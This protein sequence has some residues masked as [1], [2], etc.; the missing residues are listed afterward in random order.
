[1]RILLGILIT[2]CCSQL[3][4]AATGYVCT[5][6]GMERKIE[7]VYTGAGKVPCEV[8]Y[9]KDG[10]SQVLWNAQNEEGYCEAKAAEFVEKQRSWG[11]QCVESAAPMSDPSAPLVP[12]ELGL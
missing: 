10:A 9:T 6:G 7:V 4:L 2:L 12:E 8:L 3:A 1:M 11:W 5:Q